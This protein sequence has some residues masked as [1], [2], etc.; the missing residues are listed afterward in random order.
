MGMIYKRGKTFWIKYY[1]NGKPYY[2]SAKSKKETDARKLLKKREGEISQGKLP[3]VY[4]DGVRFDELAEDFLADC[5]INQ[6]K[7]V[8]RAE[9]SVRHL[10]EYFEGLRVTQITTPRVQVYIEQRL[11]WKRGKC[12]Q[13]EKTFLANQVENIDDPSCPYC[14]S[15]DVLVKG[16]TNATINRE[17]AA[18]KRM[19]NLGAQQTPPK[20][21]RVPYIPMLKENN[22]RKGFFEHGDFLALR[23]ALPDY[24]KGF[25][26]FGYKTGWR[27]SEI[28]GLTWDRVDLENGIVRLEVGETKNDEARTVYLDDELR[29]VFHRQREAQKQAQTL[30]PFVFPSVYGNGP[31]RQFYKAWATACEK[32]GVGKRLF[33]D[34]RR[35]AV[36]NMVRSGTPEAVAMKISGHKTREVFE[37]YNIVNNADLRL[38]AQRQEEYL[39]SQTGT[40]SGTLHT[41][42]EKRANHPSS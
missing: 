9:L 5:R 36:R 32:A 42:N 3:G 27:M 14:H 4:F 20:V 13:C 21:D 24:L 28:A 15:R 7:S 12:G 23:D 16:A 6:M 33:H 10:R 22:T 25:V 1:R 40:L 37:R 11:M 17:L 2:E 19:L 30:T 41:F 31:I 38:A 35:T 26:T 29:K 34:F 8:K 39:K 18:L